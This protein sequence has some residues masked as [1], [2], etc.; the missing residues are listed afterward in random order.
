MREVTR[1]LHC[2][3]QILSGVT[4]MLPLCSTSFVLAVLVLGSRAVNTHGRLIYLFYL[5][6]AESRLFFVRILREV[7]A[8]PTAHVRFFT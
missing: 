5:T 8:S 3:L 2:W 7:A 6:D 4:P 1:T